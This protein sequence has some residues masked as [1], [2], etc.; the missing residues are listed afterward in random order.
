MSLGDSAARTPCPTRSA[1]STS[2]HSATLAAPSSSPP[3][4]TAS[5]PARLASRKAPSKSRARPRRSSLE[6]PNPTTPWSM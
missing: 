4:G 6:S 5:S 1:S 3:C 2:T